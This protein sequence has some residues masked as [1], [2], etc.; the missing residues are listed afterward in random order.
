V[1]AAVLSLP[2]NVVMTQ[3]GYRE[4]ASA[5][6]LTCALHS[7]ASPRARRN[8]TEAPAQVSRDRATLEAMEFNRKEKA[9]M[10]NYIQNKWQLTPR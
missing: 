10:V 8:L 3:K 7:A 6:E 1:A 4:V 5:T 2:H 9:W